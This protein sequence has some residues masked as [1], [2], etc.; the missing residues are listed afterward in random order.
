M[1][2]AFEH[3]ETH[4][5]YRP[6]PVDPRIFDS[7][8]IAAQINEIKVTDPKR[9]ENVYDSLVD[10]LVH[11][12]LQAARAIEKEAEP[13][14]WTA[15]QRCVWRSSTLPI[16]QRLEVIA[17]RSLA[18]GTKAY[19]SINGGRWVVTCPFPG[20]HS[21]QL[22]SF[23]DRRFFCVECNSQAVSGQWVEVVW[24]DKPNEVEQWVVH[25]P[26]EAQH[27]LPGETQEMII[28][29]DKEHI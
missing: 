24:P 6:K 5:H 29:Q 8:N 26:A 3:A 7:R 14:S 10:Q 28:Q 22:A 17:D 19:A 2:L 12:S 15:P 4:A 18:I 1:K 11:N 9:G 25:R 13:A 27:W 21:A 23:L 20:C 16:G